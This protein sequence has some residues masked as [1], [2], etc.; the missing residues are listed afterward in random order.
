MGDVKVSVLVP[1]YNAEKYLPTC[2]DSIINQSMREIEIICVNDWSTDGC[3][4][5][6]QHYARLDSRIR[7]IAHDYNKGAMQS[8][9][10]G[11]LASHGEYILFVDSDDRIEKD[12]CLDLYA[13]ALKTGADIVHF[14]SSIDGCAQEEE[15]VGALKDSLLPFPGELYT[16]D[17]LISCFDRASYRYTLWNK[18]F[19]RSIAIE[20]VAFIGDERCD[21]SD[22]LYL[23]FLIAYFAKLYIGMSGCSYY[24]YRYGAGISTSQIRDLSGFEKLC[25]QSIVVEHIK[26]FLADQGAL[27]S[28]QQMHNRISK[29]LIDECVWRWFRELSNSDSALGFDMMVDYWGA[30][31]VIE[32]VSELFW[33]QPELVAK[34]V[35]VAKT[36]R[37]HGRP[38]RVIGVFYVSLRHGGTERVIASLI[39][40][41]QKMGYDVVLFTDEE[42]KSDDYAVDADYKR[43]IL[44]GCFDMNPQHYR[45]RTKRLREAVIAHNIDVFVHCAGSSDILLLD[46]MTIKSASIPVVVVCHEAFSASL[47][48]LGEVFYRKLSVYKFA[49]KLVVL[50]RTDVT[51]W[52][53]LGINAVYIPN[54]PSFS[55]ED[56]V[57]SRLDTN[58]VLWI[59]R[60]SEEKQCLEAVRIFSIALKDVPHAKLFILGKAASPQALTRLKDEISLLGIEEDVIICGHVVEMGY[61]Y[62]LA[63]VY[64]LTSYTESF[65][66]TLLEARAYGIPTVMYEIPHL[67]L[68]R[69]GDDIVSVDQG[70]RNAAATAI[71][72][73]L[74]DYRYRACLGSRARKGTEVFL[75]TANLSEGWNDVLR[76]SELEEAVAGARNQISEFGMILEAI[77][78]HYK[79]GVES[80]LKAERAWLE[81]EKAWYASERER[82]DEARAWHVS[83]MERVQNEILAIKNEEAKTGE[84]VKDLEVAYSTLVRFIPLHILKRIAEFIC[85]F[86]SLIKSERLND[87]G[88]N[89]WNYQRSLTL[90]VKPRK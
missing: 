77:L 23:Y 7:I 82:V 72:K 1:V 5:I 32:S 4:E 36:L 41:W 67:E 89:L 79:M 8:R 3:K 46:L 70:N 75:N 49:D 90:V 48:Y 26:Q 20:A 2:L 29:M 56:V 55:I 16:S 73:L 22:D 40:I 86:A 28:Y 85:S 19:R 15:A 10:T 54:P 42:P 17:I 71:I 51:F 24:T 52:R 38:T 66:M 39:S 53:E 9:K 50:S 58:N 47:T 74:K 80:K 87:V 18:L 12:C 68:V 34:K 69:S 37:F 65:S 60:L 57:P 21:L 59:G 81:S 30:S 44:P 83:E 84:Y 64:L 63:A 76:F 35:E 61:F 13:E 88:R 33:S 25:A 27:A 11:I 14:C 78:F 45:L 43:V 31:N 62:S 6:L